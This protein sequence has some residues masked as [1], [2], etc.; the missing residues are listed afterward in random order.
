LPPAALHD[1]DVLITVEPNGR[2]RLRSGHDPS[3]TVSF[4]P[5]VRE[6]S[7]VRHRHKYAEGHVPYERGFTFRDGSNTIGAH[8]ASM[9]EFS[10][11]LERVASAT[12]V[13][14]ARRH[15]FSRWIREV[16]HDR[17]L[18]DAVARCEEDLRSQDV[19]GFRTALKQLLALR[20]DLALEAS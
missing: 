16:F 2:A 17:L 15:D 6:I 14:H 1:A 4:A 7:H 8:V 19:S 3:R 9:A 12:L 11:E 10:A 13:H 18:A 5:D 20:Y